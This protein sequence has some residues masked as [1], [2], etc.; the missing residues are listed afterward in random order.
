MCVTLK[1]RNGKT[2]SEECHLDAYI[3]LPPIIA[4][5]CIIPGKKRHSRYQSLADLWGEAEF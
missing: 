2:R 5:G 3:H 1:D 4:H